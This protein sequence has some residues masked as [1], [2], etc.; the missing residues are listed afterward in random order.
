[1][2]KKLLIA[3]ICIS[4]ISAFA[5]SDKYSLV[6]IDKPKKDKAE[7]DHWFYGTVIAFTPVTAPVGEFWFEPE[8]ATSWIYGAYD[9]KGNF[10]KNPTIFSVQNLLDVQTGIASFIG[11]EL[12]WSFVNNVC[13]GQKS[14]HFTDLD[15]NLGFQIST[16]QKDSW[17]PD[18]R[19]LF[20][21]LF[22]T[23]KYQ[24]LDPNKLGADLTGLGSYQTGVNFVFQKFFPRN[25][26]HSISISGS[27]G[28]IF[29]SSVKVHGISAFGGNEQTNTTVRPGNYINSYF[30]LQYEFSRQWGFTIETNYIVGQKGKVKHKSK[31]PDVSSPFF[32]QLSIAPEIQH[33]FSENLG[34]AIVGWASVYGKN[35]LAFAEMLFSVLY[36]F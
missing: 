32:E 15:I 34:V 35:S 4:S 23:G 8:F 30:V 2:L 22:P 24:H 27:V 17:I 21:E 6:A 29:P 14:S 13:E 16:D 33:T 3:S 9:R 20:E 12:F 7:Y 31:N 25:N 11:A 28:F 26:K 19:I 18:F 36:T 10:V 5:D 1:M